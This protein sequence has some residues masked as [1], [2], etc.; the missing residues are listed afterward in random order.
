MWGEITY[1]FPNFNSATVEVS[2]WISMISFCILLGMWLLIHASDSKV[3]EANVKPTDSRRKV[4]HVDVKPQVIGNVTL[5]AIT[6]AMK[7]VPT[8]SVKSLQFIWRLGASICHLQVP[9][10][11]S[12]DKD[13]RVPKL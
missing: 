2:E 7:L 3:H 5:T 1:S 4:Y 8:H 9:E 10:L 13:E 11:Q 6:E 12:L